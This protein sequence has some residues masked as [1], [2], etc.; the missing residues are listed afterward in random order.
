MS[1]YSLNQIGIGWDT[2]VN[3]AK[4]EQIFNFLKTLNPGYLI[5]G[6]YKSLYFKEIPALDNGHPPAFSFIAFAIGNFLIKLFGFKYY[7]F[8]IANVILGTIFIYVITKFLFYKVSKNIVLSIV[9]SIILISIP[10]F[11]VYSVVDT[12]DFPVLAFSSFALVILINKFKD[13]LLQLILFSIFVLL[14]LYVK[15]TFLFLIPVLL[16]LFFINKELV[17]FCKSNFKKIIYVEILVI[18]TITFLFW[19]NLIFNF[20][21][22]IL[23]LYDV[24]FLLP[25]KSINY[26][27]FGY[28]YLTETPLFYLIIFLTSVFVLLFKHSKYRTIYLVWVLPAILY[29]GLIN[30]QYDVVRQFLFLSLPFVFSIFLLL[31]YIHNKFIYKVLLIGILLYSIYLL[32]LPTYKKVVYSNIILRGYTNDGWGLTLPKVLSYVKATYPK[33]RIYF[34]PAAFLL[35]YYDL[36]NYEI[37]YDP[38]FADIFIT[39]TKTS[40]YLEERVL[41]EKYFIKDIN[42]NLLGDTLEVWIKK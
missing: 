10:Y 21:Y 27:S 20:N 3:L 19:P 35:T 30:R 41:R 9:P 8:H 7:F 22:E 17:K 34:S 18:Y 1:V 13:K 16:Y 40:S 28:F 36:K 14:A 37:I 23:R 33:G 29:L 32:T 4:G 26:V 11:F 15:L 39:T 24:Y 31:K 12:K 2:S 6:A 25:S 38:Y 42:F 5:D